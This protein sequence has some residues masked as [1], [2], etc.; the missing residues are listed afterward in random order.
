[1]C[2]LD[3][4]SRLS[5][6]TGALPAALPNCS[7]DC[8]YWI[9]ARAPLGD[10]GNVER[11]FNSGV[12]LGKE[13][14]A[15]KKVGIVRAGQQ[16]S[17]RSLLVGTPR[18]IC[19]GPAPLRMIPFASVVHQKCSVHGPGPAGSINPTRTDLIPCLHS[20]DTRTRQDARSV[21]ESMAS[22]AATILIVF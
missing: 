15:A 2:L 7:P 8:V 5:W 11:Q 22:T 10:I 12:N 14:G 16:T 13:G 9:A 1:M 17:T 3:R 19:D 4:R 21:L 6:P 18:I 20:F